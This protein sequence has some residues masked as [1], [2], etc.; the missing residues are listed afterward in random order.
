M[1]HTL[2]LFGII[3]LAAIMGFTM[4]ACNNDGDGGTSPFD[5]SWAK[6]ADTF[7][8]SGSNVIYKYGGTGWIRGVF[9]STASTII[10]TFTEMT[11]NDGSSWSDIPPESEVSGSGNYTLS[12]NTLTLSNFHGEA[13]SFNGTWTKQ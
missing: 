8:F 5:G 12:G 10:F 4:T 7:V 1:K 13:D 11:D 6:G 2:K 9:T 3:A